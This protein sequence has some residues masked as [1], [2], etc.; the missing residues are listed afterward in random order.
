M[1]QN[2]LPI[3]QRRA[4]QFSAK[5]CLN[6]R[7][8]PQTVLLAVVL[9]HLSGQFKHISCY[10]TEPFIS[11]TDLHF[12]HTGEYYLQK[13]SMHFP[14]EPPE[15]FNFKQSKTYFKVIYLE[16]KSMLRVTI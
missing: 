8:L 3:L 14:L 13:P 16:F 15:E 9:K 10:E 12:S 2:C 11:E 4:K 1:Q 5:L 6:H 7:R